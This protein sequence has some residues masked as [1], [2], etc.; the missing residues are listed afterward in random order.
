LHGSEMTAGMRA[1][2]GHDWSTAY[3]ELK[4]TLRA[5]EAEPEHLEALAESAWWLGAIDDTIAARERAFSIYVDAHRDVDAARV[6][7]EVAE[8]HAHRL[9]ASEARGWMRRAARLLDGLG[10]TPE[11][12]QLRRL[13]SVFA[14]GA[15]GGVDHALELAR[16][17]ERIGKVTGDRDLEML[18]LHD[19]GRF[20]VATGEVD[21]GFNLME[22][23]MVSVVTGELTPFVTG[24]IY[25]NMIETCASTADYKRAS[26]W[27]DRAMRWCEE[28][29]HAGGYPGVCRVRRSELMRLRGAWPAAEAE[30]NRAASELRDFGPYMAEAF[31]EIG[32][33]RLHR[34]DLDGADEAFKR[35]HSL[36][37]N[38]MPGMALS[39]VARGQADVAHSMIESVLQG[40]ESPLARI[41][42]LPGAVEIAL[43]ASALDQAR[44]HSEELSQLT[45]GFGSEL[46][47]SFALQARA[48]VLTAEGRHDEAVAIHRKVVES[49]IPHG[50]PYETARAR[51]DLGLSLIA[52]GIE[53]LGRLEFETAR[54]EL[55]RLGAATAL[56]WLRRLSLDGRRTQTTSVMM[57]TDMVDSTSLIG[58]VGDEAWGDLIAWHDAT[59]R[60]LIDR[61]HGAEIDHAGDGF[62]VSFESATDA[63]R[64]AMEIQRALQSHRRE[65]GFSP[66]VR[67][68]IH[69]G[70]VLESERRLLG[71]NV[72]LA[73]RI[74][75]A[76][77]GDEILV[78]RVTGAELGHGYRIEDMRTLAVKGIDESVEVGAVAWS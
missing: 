15:E 72:H 61:H 13:E 18:G 66:R 31:N 9:E 25:C 36:G 24:R 57:F 55:E 1:W 78:S 35:A 58:L 39:K 70:P 34:G 30:A 54:E 28:M 59:L 8:N 52:N 23:A 33:L 2:S 45:D 47:D 3:S 20:L 21:E 49:L 29:G 68:G 43:E 22:E 75:A 6:A 4:A 77:K 65:S 46:F 73:A 7:V 12:G 76:A 16:E 10:E 60:T 56:E 40:T 71:H 41:K 63:V 67:I 48:R 5:P 19:R 64:C 69:A 11:L 37:A 32:L 53:D 44:Q 62:F 51:C 42:L 74:G 50:L 27:S 17:V 38:A 26:E 14:V